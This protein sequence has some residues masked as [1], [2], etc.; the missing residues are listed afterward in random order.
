MKGPIAFLSSE[1]NASELNARTSNPSKSNE[2]VSG[3]PCWR[4]RYCLDQLE[5]P[6]VLPGCNRENRARCWMAWLNL[7]SRG[8]ICGSARSIQI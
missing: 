2:L 4:T 3:T 5:L 1:L 7:F 6:E 8:F